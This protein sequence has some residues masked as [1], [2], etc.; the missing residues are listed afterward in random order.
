MRGFH[1]YCL[2]FGVAFALMGAAAC[3]RDW[4]SLS[5][6]DAWERLESTQQ[7]IIASDQNSSD[8]QNGTAQTVADEDSKEAAV[9]RADSKTIEG[10]ETISGRSPADGQKAQ[11]NALSRLAADLAAQRRAADAKAAEIQEYRTIIKGI[12]EDLAQ[13]FALLARQPASAGSRQ[14][15]WNSAQI[16]LSRQ[17]SQVDLMARAVRQI[18]MQSRQAAQL[19]EGKAVTAQNVQIVSYIAG[20]SQR[21]AG[22]LSSA[23]AKLQQDKEKFSALGRP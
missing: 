12:R 6:G 18:E 22:V 2:R 7:K 20:L 13:Q 21:V 3:S 10:S 4:P 23:Q 8:D 1:F 5:E 19:I 9:K 16:N 15:E 14:Q 17:E 11:E